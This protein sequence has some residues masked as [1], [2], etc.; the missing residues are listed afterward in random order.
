M[1]VHVLPMVTGAV[2]VAPMLLT[3]ITA[4]ATTT[5]IA[6]SGLRLTS[7]KSKSNNQPRRSPFSKD[8]G[9]NIFSHSASA[10]AS[11]TATAR[12]KFLNSLDRLD[13]FNTPTSQRTELVNLLTNDNP[14]PR[15]G[16][17]NSFNPIAVAT[18][19]VVYAPHISTG[20]KL[21]TTTFGTGGEDGEGGFDPVLYIMKPI[22]RMVSHARYDIPWL[23]LRGWLSVSGTY[24][25]HD[26]DRICR[27]DFDRAWV[28]PISNNSSNDDDKPY[29]CFDDVPSSFS[30]TL[31]QKLGQLGFVKSVSVFPVS[32]LDDDTIVFDFELLKTRICARKIQSQQKEQKR[33][34]L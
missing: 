23:K 12:D 25:S 6:F 17:T 30:K 10:P 16:S 20:G 29:E 24:D 33:F 28:K 11:T 14:T 31:I 18:W 9:S 4:A 34:S 7:H 8:H 26:N 19:S 2:L 22:Q 3:S 1:M 27:V 5:K 21:L 32:Y 15:P 13:G